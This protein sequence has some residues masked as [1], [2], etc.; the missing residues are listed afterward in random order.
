MAQAL[1]R[2]K[3]MKTTL[4][5]Y[6]KQITPEAFKSGMRLLEAAAK[7]GNGSK[8]SATIAYRIVSERSISVRWKV[9]ERARLD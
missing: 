1:L 4:D 3:S 5:I 2:H 9:D 6:K 7:N 8:S